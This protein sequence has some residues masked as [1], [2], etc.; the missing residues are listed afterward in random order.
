[1]FFCPETMGKISQLGTAEE[2]MD[3]CSVDEIFIP[4]VDFGH[5][6]AR[7]HGEFCGFAAY[8]GLLSKMQAKLGGRAKNMHVHFSKIEF[9]AGGEVRHLKM[10]DSSFG[11]DFAP[12][13]EAVVKHGFTPVILS[14][15]DGTQI[16]DA[17]EMK[18][19]Y[20]NIKEKW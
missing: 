15:S 5:L 14:E 4:T 17:L 19:I 6:Y 20:D 3:F 2:I 9:S 10:S 13:A 11:P 16:E 7:S 18:K 1:M 12:L 8:D